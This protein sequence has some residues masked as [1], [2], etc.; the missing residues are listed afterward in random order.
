[1]LPN[2]GSS[3]ILWRDAAVM[4]QR[5][6]TPYP[7]PAALCSSISDTGFDFFKVPLGYPSSH[8]PLHLWVAQRCFHPVSYMFSQLLTPNIIATNCHSFA[9]LLQPYASKI[10]G[11]STSL[12]GLSCF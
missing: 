9:L 12:R 8:S 5:H 2:A 10:S 7:F 6:P 11:I 1:M 4:A 3:L